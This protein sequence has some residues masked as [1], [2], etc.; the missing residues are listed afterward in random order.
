[1]P[2]GNGHVT[3]LASFDAGNGTLALMISASSF[4]FED[5]EMGKVGLLTIQLPSR[6]GSALAPGF[7]QTFDPEDATVRFSIPAV[8]TSTPR[9]VVPT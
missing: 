1:M 7:S 5:G 9:L 8:R 3:A 6:G 4:W 2:I